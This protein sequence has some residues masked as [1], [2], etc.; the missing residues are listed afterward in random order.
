[1][2]EVAVRW[3]PTGLSLRERTTTIAMLSDAEL[4]R[5]QAQ[6]GPV[7]ERFLQGRKLLREMVGES[8][9]ISPVEVEIVAR[10]KDCGGPH[11]RPFAVGTTLG[12]SVSH[13][14]GGVVAAVSTTGQVGVDAEPSVGS[15]VRLA[16]IAEVAGRGSVAHWTRVEAVLKA[17][18]R[19]LRVDPRQVDIVHV[20]GGIEALVG[21]GGIRYRITEPIL[22][23]GLQVS[24]AVAV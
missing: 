22:A 8:L 14:A 13:C 24:I 2:S 16:A 6:S 19:G 5:Y 23:P 3:S 21:G 1:M 7:G 17:D 18:G 9:G 4:A 11:G 20:D 10:C 12:L 15:A